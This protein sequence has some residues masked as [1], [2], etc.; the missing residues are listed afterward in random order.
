MK[1]FLLR[2]FSIFLLILSFS[3][4]AC[5]S[6]NTEQAISSYDSDY[7]IGLKLLQEGNVKGAKQ[8]F[9]RCKKNG[10]YYC[11]KKSAEALVGI[12]DIQERNEAAQSLIE[13]FNDEDSLIIAVKQFLSAD[14][15]NK[16]LELTKGLNFKSAK[17]ELIKIRLECLKLRGDDYYEDEVYKWFTCC[18]IS[19]EHYQ[20][21]NDTYEH[22]DFSLLENEILPTIVE[23]SSSEEEISFTPK[24]FIINYRIQMYR[25]DYTYTFANAKQILTYLE[26]GEIEPFGLIASDLGK[27]FLYGDMSFANNGAK[28]QKL[29]QKYQGTEAEFFFWFYAGR[30]YEKSGMYY[31]RI[32]N[33]FES[34]IFVAQTPEQKDN[35]LWYLLN[36][37]LKHS[38]DDAITLIENSSTKWHDP[39]YFED[40]FESLVSPLL[41]GQHY[42]Y[43]YKIY[44]ALDG[45]MCDEIV[46]QYA[47]IFARLAQEKLTEG[48]EE[49]ILQA[50]ERS[51]RSGSAVYYKIMSA[52]T[53]GKNSSDLENILCSPTKSNSLK[54]EEKSTSKA[55]SL[56]TKSDLSNLAAKTLLEGYV[57][58]GFPELIYPTWLALYKE[59]LPQETYF[60]L[61]DF[62][63]QCASDNH[64]FGVQGT[65][66]AARGLS[67]ASK[68]LTKSQMQKAYPTLYSK[69]IEENAQKYEIPTSVIYAL[70]R[71]ESFFDE[72]VKSTAGAIGLTQLMESTGSDIARKLRIYDYDLENPEINIEFGTFY[73]NELISRLDNSTLMSFFSYN[74]GITRA[75]RW[76]KTN[77][78]PM[79][80]FLET[81]PYTE[82]REYGRKLISA[83]SMYEYLYSEDGDSAFFETVET[84]VK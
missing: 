30:L 22:P 6:K 40:F 56:T 77:R 70:V 72:D 51:C 65:R 66:I 68:N 2:K 23:N 18:N 28:F 61:A 63:Q 21:Y 64:E 43:F 8:K 12:G 4:V 13:Q 26:N 55:N 59:G 78:L 7:F 73:L 42:S 9:L 76:K 52:Y 33:S 36:V 11:A 45:V 71:S 44:K 3:F 17:N 14:E 1:T 81:I 69:L 31:S 38:M 58:Y 29:A 47:Y 24:Q 37:T 53:L 16:I 25:R 57:I 54:E 83:T 19:K 62:L 84:L 34:A 67:N 49:Q 39:H 32:K 5:S 46:A 10:S 74:A 50:L 41:A 75:R 35:A 27:A 20:F 80:L 79:D 82:T 15:I 60:Y 48:T